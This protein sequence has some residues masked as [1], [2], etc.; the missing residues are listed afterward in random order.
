MT[1]FNQ[2][3]VFLLNRMTAEKIDAKIRTG[4]SDRKKKKELGFWN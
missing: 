2:N 1:Q 3:A 4:R